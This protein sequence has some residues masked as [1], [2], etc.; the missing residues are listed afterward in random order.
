[1]PLLLIFDEEKLPPFPDEEEQAL[2]T[3]LGPEGLK[4]IDETIVR[5]VVSNHRKV[6]RVIFDAM[7]AGEFTFSDALVYIY[8]RRIIEMVASGRLEAQGNLT[9]PRFSEIRIPTHQG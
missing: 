3:K 2:V 6:A 8:T 9:K 7:K 1:M 4:R 5:S